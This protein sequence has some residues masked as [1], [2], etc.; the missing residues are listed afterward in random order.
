MDIAAFARLSPT[1]LAE[2]V[3]RDRVMDPGIRP[4][5]GPMGRLAGPGNPLRAVRYSTTVDARR[6]QLPATPEPP[7][8]KP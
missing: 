8:P 7:Q 2:V 3:T 6:L 5:W 1:T 4:L